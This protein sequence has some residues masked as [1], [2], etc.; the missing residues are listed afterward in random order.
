MLS[1]SAACVAPSDAVGASP[2]REG[3]QVS[4]S[5]ISPNLVFPIGFTLI[6]WEVTKGNI[7]NLFSLGSPLGP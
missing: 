1:P 2:Q 5:L 3:F 7:N 4:F 6:F